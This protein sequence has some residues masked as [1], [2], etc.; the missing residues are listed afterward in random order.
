[1]PAGS[2][3]AEIAAARPVDRGSL[4]RHLP[5]RF[6]QPVQ[7]SDRGLRHRPGQGHRQG[8]LRQRERL[9]V[10]RD[11]G[12]PT[13]PVVARGLGRHRRPQHDD[14]LRPVEADRLLQRVLPLRAED[15]GPARLQGRPPSRA[16]P[17]SA[18]ARPTA[19][20]AWTTSRSGR[21]RPSP[22]APTATPDAWCCSRKAAWTPSPATTRCWPGSPPRIRTPSCPSRQ[23]FTAEPYGIGVNAAQVDLVRFVNARLAQ[24]RENGEWTAIYDRWLRVGARVRLRLRRAPSTAG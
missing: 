1:M 23:A 6:P 17:G 14:Q 21:R 7:R 13:D 20:R 22:S 10:A 16:W 18:S 24:M 9:R 19:P 8:D 12:R 11:H 15:P 2:T 4:R 3:M 5:A